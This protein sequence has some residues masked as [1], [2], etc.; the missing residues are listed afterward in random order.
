MKKYYSFLTHKVYN[1]KG[2]MAIA[3]S[4]FLKAKAE[5][6]AERLAQSRAKT[7]EHLNS[8]TAKIKARRATQT[9]KTWE[10]I[11]LMVKFNKSCV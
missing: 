4:R 7:Q 1:N 2:L 3:E 10:I 6:E 5:K 8:I 9:A 11:N